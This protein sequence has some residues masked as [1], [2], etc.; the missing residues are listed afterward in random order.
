MLAPA[1]STPSALALVAETDDRRLL[2]LMDDIY[3]NAW[4]DSADPARAPFDKDAPPSWP[5]TTKPTS[6]YG[7]EADLAAPSWSTGVGIRWDEPSGS[8]GFSWSQSEQD[9]GWG[10]ATYEGISLGK[11]SVDIAEPVA[12]SGDDS[13]SVEKT[14]TDDVEHALSGGETVSSTPSPKFEPLPSSPPPPPTPPLQP[15]EPVLPHDLEAEV[16]PAVFAPAS[17][18]AFGSFASG[19]PEDASP[20]PGFAVDNTESDPWG[21]AWADANPQQEEEEEVADEWERAKQEKAK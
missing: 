10:A 13:E 14:P 21:S 8:P 12:A 2:T 1:S 9:A 7:E 16:N 6:S 5:S 18:D 15:L 3:Q 17:P 11:L 4:S 20:S 19:L